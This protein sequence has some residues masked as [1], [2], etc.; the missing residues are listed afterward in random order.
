VIRFVLAIA[1]W[2]CDHPESQM[3]AQVKWGSNVSYP[4]RFC[5]CHAADMSNF[6]VSVKAHNDASFRNA[7]S[8]AHG[9]REEIDHIP[10][11]ER[12][13]YGFYTDQESFVVRLISNE[14]LGSS[15]PS[16]ALGASWSLPLCALHV[17]LS[18]GLVRYAVDWFIESIKKGG[19]PLGRD[20]TLEQI[21]KRARTTGATVRTSVY[22]D[23]LISLDESFAL[24]PSFSMRRPNG[25]LAYMTRFKNGGIAELKFLTG[26]DYLCILQQL[27]ALI[28]FSGE[29][30]MPDYALEKFLKLFKS[31]HRMVFL[32]FKTPV[33]SRDVQ[34]EF[35]VLTHEFANEL[36]NDS[37]FSRA[38]SKVEMQFSKVHMLRHIGELTQFY[39][40]AGNWES[41][42]EEAAHKLFAKSAYKRTNHS[43]DAQE[44]MLRWS[45]KLNQAH[46]ILA[47]YGDLPSWKPELSRI[48][49]YPFDLKARNTPTRLPVHDFVKYGM[50]SYLRFIFPHVDFSVTDRERYAAELQNLTLEVHLS[51]QLVLNGTRDIVTANF[52]KGKHDFVEID[53]GTSQRAFGKLQ[54]IVHAMGTAFVILQHFCCHTSYPEKHPFV[55]MPY[56]LNKLDSRSTDRTLWSIYKLEDIKAKKNVIPDPFNRECYFVNDMLML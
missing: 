51:T 55:G 35:D 36:T 15:S 9:N 41:G 27:P 48:R 4:C 20:A 56:I 22:S 30:Y 42:R 10:E 33:W 13:V 5:S 26:R 50:A 25:D 38:F 37:G 2:I 32:V 18:Q 11:D 28:A 31:L 8:I 23:K 46:G 17:F 45:S 44:Q 1:Y 47:Q 54:A 34:T 21:Q 3:L 49:K 29:K 53:G 14:H 24:V 12:K 40:V 52:A 19:W 16:V 6:A 7:Y 39:G 43:A